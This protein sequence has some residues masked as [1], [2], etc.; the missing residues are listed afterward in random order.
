MKGNFSF[1]AL[2]DKFD[3]CDGANM[4]T[5]MIYVSSPLPQKFE[6][7][8]KYLQRSPKIKTTTHPP[9]HENNQCLELLAPRLYLTTT[10]IVG[11][12]VDHKP[13]DDDLTGFQDH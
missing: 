1:Q 3:V 9:H 13:T 7:R 12:D 2:R 5:S 8:N 11:N 4:D 10:L 6:Q